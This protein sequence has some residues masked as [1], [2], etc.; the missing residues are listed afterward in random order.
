[1]FD[2]TGLEVD[3]VLHLELIRA[4]R[5]HI[6]HFALLENH[7]FFVDIVKIPK[8]TFKVLAG[9]CYSISLRR[10]LYSSDRS[11]RGKLVGEDP[12]SSCW[13]LCGNDCI[14]SAT[15]H[16]SLPFHSPS[17]LDLLIQIDK[18]FSC[19]LLSNFHFFRFFMILPVF[20]DWKHS[21]ELSGEGC[22]DL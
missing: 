19:V 9:D 20:I 4:G 15:F 6:D 8:S 2:E 18:I 10:Q 17:F 1:M 3:C 16:Y 7:R 14:R 12:A 5:E 13:C 11:M 22:N 21:K